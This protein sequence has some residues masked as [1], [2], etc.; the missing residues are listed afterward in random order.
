MKKISEVMSRGVETVR[1]DDTLRSAAE[2]MKVLDV[3]VLPVCDGVRVLGMVTDRDL[4]V[5]GLADGR[6]PDTRVSEVMTKDVA[7]CRED[8]HV[9]ACA[10]K[11]KEKQ[12]RRLIVLDADKKLVGIVSLGDLSQEVDRKMSGEVLKEVSEPSAIH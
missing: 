6:S 8:E 4:V 10:R 1:P 3:G 12:I 7:W 11:M 2:K 9:D 5:R